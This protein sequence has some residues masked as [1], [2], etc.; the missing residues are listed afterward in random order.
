MPKNWSVVL[1]VRSG[2]NAILNSK[3]VRL[4]HTIRFKLII[5]FVTLFISPIVFALN[6]TELK[7]IV[8]QRLLGDR[9]GACWAVAVIDT[10]VA[11][12]IICA[13][14]KTQRSITAN[15]AFE[16]GSVTKTMNGALLS[17]LIADNKLNLD[18]PLDR[19][20]GVPVPNVD[21]KKIT[22]RHLVSHTSGLPALPLRFSP[23]NLENPYA[24]LTESTLLNSL[25]EVQLPYAPG[26]SSRY[27]N[28][29]AMLLSLVISKAA[30][31]NY[32]A[33]ISERLFKPVGM[34]SAFITKPTTNSL[35]SA[36]AQ[37]H[38]QSGI[39]TSAWDFPVNYA[40]VGGV[41]ANLNDMVRYIQIQMRAAASSKDSL[42]Q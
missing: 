8:E 5:F 36:I 30:D 14:S 18:D 22:L 35:A 27:S 20:V 12:A 13:N 29:G 11:T 31:K 7:T 25:A 19:F 38:L 34:D 16:I 9:T 39:T 23:K 40:G 6:S 10:E 33:F 3:D 32:E 2:L 28:W 21:G 26:T 24:D 42:G 41:H 37:G 4:I 1:L 17:M 15:T